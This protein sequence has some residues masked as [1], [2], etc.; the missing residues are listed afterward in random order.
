MTS[1]TSHSANDDA[2]EVASE[3]AVGDGRKHPPTQ[4][5]AHAHD[6]AARALVAIAETLAACEA[7]GLRLTP[8]RRHVLEAL[9][10]THTPMS[11]YEL[12]DALVAHGGKRVAPITVYR[13][14]DFLLEHGFAHKLESRNA[15]VSCP[16]HHG[17]DELVVFLICECCGG[18]DECGSDELGEALSHLAGRQG[19]VPRARVMELAGRCAHCAQG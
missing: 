12:I 4:A 13:A 17:R 19:F 3:H 14:L 1:R 8:I 10:A 15:F 6:H 18:V 11:A 16:F 2:H 7:R 9:Y 5:C